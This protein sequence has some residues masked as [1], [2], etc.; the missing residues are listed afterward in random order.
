MPGYLKQTKQANTEER[1]DS[2]GTEELPSVPSD[3]LRAV[4]VV[5]IS[6]ITVDSS[7]KKTKELPQPF[8]RRNTKEQ[9][10]FYQEMK[11]LYVQPKH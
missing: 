8:E 2:V 7:E 6:P 5:E 1:N 4:E 10:E 3:G 9:D 11:N